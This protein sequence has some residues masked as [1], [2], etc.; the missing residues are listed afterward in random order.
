M[1]AFR[2]PIPLF[3]SGC[4][5]YYLPILLKFCGIFYKIR[6]LLR[7]PCLKMLH[8]SFVYSHLIY[9]IEIYANTYT[10]YLQKLCILNNKIIRILFSNH[11]R[12]HVKDLYLII[13]SSPLIKV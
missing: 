8:I 11:T 2:L 9:G 1:A 4:I 13:D 12:T 3:F 10:T 7:F 5:F 6:D